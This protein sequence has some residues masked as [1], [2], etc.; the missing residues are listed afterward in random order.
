MQCTVHTQHFDLL[1]RTLISD[2]WTVVIPRLSAAILCGLL[3]LIVGSHLAGQNPPAAPLRLVTNTGSR[4]LPTVVVNDVEMIALDE[5]ASTF[6][7][8][9][10]EDTLARAVTVTGRGKTIVLTPDQ[11]IASVAGRLVSLPAA[12]A[13]VA[14]RWYVPVEFIPRALSLITDTKLDLRKG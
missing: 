4:P 1:R 5:L 3:V 8:T 6:Q 14:A 2:D 9:V 12:P 13:R 11:S 10:R 7:V